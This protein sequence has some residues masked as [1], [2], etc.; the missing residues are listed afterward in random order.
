MIYQ[1]TSPFN[2]DSNSI[3]L[4]TD[5]VQPEPYLRREPFCFIA[6]TNSTLFVIYTGPNRV[7]VEDAKLLHDFQ[8]CSDGVKGV[9]GNPVV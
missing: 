1:T 4:D 7:I 6:N 2:V 5:Y 9:G 8:A 3:A